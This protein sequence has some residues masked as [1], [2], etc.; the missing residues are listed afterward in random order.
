MS[1]RSATFGTSAG[2]RWVPDPE[3]QRTSVLWEVMAAMAATDVTALH[4]R[5]VADPELYW[6]TVTG[7]LDIRFHRPYRA[8]LD[9]SNGLPFPRWFVDGGLNLVDTCIRS[10]VAGGRGDVDAVVT[11]D[12]RGGRSTL[13]YAGLSRDAARLAGY[14]HE[15]GVRKGDCVGLFLPMT[16]HATVAFFACAWLGA[17]AIPAFSGYGP[18]ALSTRLRDCGAKALLTADGFQRKGKPVAM[19]AIARAAVADVPTIE[20]V[21]CVDGPADASEAGGWISWADALDAGACL[22]R[23]EPEPTGPDDPVMVIYTS[24]T[25]GR[26]KGIVHSHAGFVVKAASDFGVAFDLKPEDR[27]FWIT[28]LGWL[29]GPLLMV[30]NGARGSTAVYYVGAPDHPDIG[31]VWRVCERERVTMLGI[32]PTAVRGMASAG[33][34]SPASTFDLSALRVLLSTGEPWDPAAWRWLFE[35]VGRERLPIINYTG[36]TEI[37]GGILTCYTAL[38]LTECAFTG[39]V[40]GLDADVLGAD[41]QPVTGQPGELAIRN[42]WPG[43]THGFWNDPQR[44]LDTYWSGFENIWM[45]GDLAVHDPDGYWYVTGRSDDT[46]KVAGRRVGPGEIEDALLQ[47]PAIAQAAA[48]GIPDEVKGQVIAAFVVPGPHQHIDPDEITAHVGSRL[49]RSLVPA[50]IEVVDALPRTRSG[51]VLRRVIRARYTGT[52]PGDLSTLEDPAVVARLPVSPDA[53][54]AA[55]AGE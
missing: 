19:S 40:I 17:V 23:R 29:M 35:E 31:Q 2:A 13:T 38:P 54:V 1:D 14:L 10:K 6:R 22:P 46:M 44:Y 5:A 27:L 25:T 18:D 48:V 9:T 32:S 30:A 34:P 7:I 4:E 37:G 47:H 43:M 33:T 52:D 41:G 15:R 36:G 50:R 24:G 11:W 16:P 51:K 55:G 8:V 42:V 28:D 39:P 12:E 3:G 21:V 49:G 45:H 53:P 26:P 20:T